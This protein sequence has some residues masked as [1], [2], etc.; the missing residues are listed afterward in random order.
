VTPRV[1]AIATVVLG[2]ATL[3]VA[4]AFSYLPEVAAI[5]GP[6]EAPIADF[7]RAATQDHLDLVFGSP[8]NPDVVAAMDAINRLDL[9]AFI[10]AYALFLI[11]AA[12]ML[13]RGARKGWVWAMIGPVL[14]GAGA[15][16]VETSSQLQ[17]TADW[18]RAE[19][20]LPL[21]APAHWAKY[22]ALGLN[23][24]AAAAFCLLQ[25]PRRWL[26]GLAALPALPAVLAAL[27]EV[28]DPPRL[29]SAVFALF[30][31]VLLLVACGQAL[32]RG[33]KPV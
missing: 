20:L 17:L 33:A 13:A 27:F 1:S 4:V 5:Y 23:A 7:Q 14:V 12:L 29:F 24:A 11:A 16:I 15:D 31:V 28:F 26:L 25:R 19:A 21:I 3:G 30:W 2:L 10:P 22:G 9:F 18:A 32:R 8:P 6:G